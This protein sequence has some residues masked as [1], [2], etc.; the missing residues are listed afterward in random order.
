MEGSITCRN[1]QNDPVTTILV[2]TEGDIQML[3]V[4]VMPDDVN[5]LILDFFHK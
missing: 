4:S 3:L 1:D 2:H 5:H